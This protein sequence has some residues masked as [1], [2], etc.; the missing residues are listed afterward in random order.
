M[1]MQVM[2]EDRVFELVSKA[3]E[4]DQL[5]VSS[6][7]IVHEIFYLRLECPLSS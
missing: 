1:F 4:F 7:S 3:Q 2:T 5:K 6:D